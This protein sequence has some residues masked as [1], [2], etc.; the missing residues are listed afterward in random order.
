ML[1]RSLLEFMMMQ[2]FAFAAA[3]SSLAVAQQAA[4]PE[5]CGLSLRL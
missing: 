5:P 1:G 3:L 2:A 4:L